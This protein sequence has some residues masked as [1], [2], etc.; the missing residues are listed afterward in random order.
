V[1][2]HV[3]VEEE[4][5]AVGGFMGWSGH[6]WVVPDEFMVQRKCGPGGSVRQGPEA[7]GSSGGVSKSGV[8]HSTSLRS[9]ARY[10]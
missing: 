7:G 10:K 1:Y 8:T 6:A 9:R 4:R 3:Y 5:E 2:R